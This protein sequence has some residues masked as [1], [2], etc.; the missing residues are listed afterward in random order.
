MKNSLSLSI[1][2][3]I[4]TILTINLIQANPIINEIELNPQGAD[5]SN[6][7]IELYSQEQI[8]L[9]DWKLINNDED[10]FLLTQTF[11]GYLI[12]RKISPA[13]R[14]GLTCKA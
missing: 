2:I 12:I 8:S 1:I 6:E 13:F 11:Q 10:E 7:W 4:S 9:K 14:L 3:F 5:K